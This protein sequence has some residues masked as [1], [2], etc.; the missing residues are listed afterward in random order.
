MTERELKKL[1]RTELL[2]L[3]LVQTKE[4]ERLQIQLEEARQKL[5]DRYLQIQE[6]GDLA[7]AVLAVNGVMEAAQA[8]ARQYLDNISKMEADARLQCENMLAEARNEADRIRRDAGL[9]TKFNSHAS[10][11]EE[12]KISAAEGT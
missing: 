11:E 6:T 12:R 10:S 4:V 9:H 5:H 1:G 7:H 2:E 8:A 3:L